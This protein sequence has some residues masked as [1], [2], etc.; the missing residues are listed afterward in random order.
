MP[1]VFDGGCAVQASSMCVQASVQKQAM[2]LEA[3][4]QHLQPIIM[5][6]LADMGLMAWRNY[7]S[8]VLDKDQDDDVQM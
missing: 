4:K 3:C 8:I 5:E 6:S 7:I 2:R 1:P